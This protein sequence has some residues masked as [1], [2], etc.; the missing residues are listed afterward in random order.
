MQLPSIKQTYENVGTKFIFTQFCVKLNLNSYLI[1]QIN[2]LYLY[3]K[4][5]SK[6]ALSQNMAAAIRYSYTILM[7][8]RIILRVRPSINCGINN[9]YFES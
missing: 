3:I 1:L 5:L 9:H 2:N 4:P 7:I 6:F 8:M